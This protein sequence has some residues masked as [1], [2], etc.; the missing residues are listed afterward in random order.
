M[1]ES[2]PTITGYHIEGLDTGVYPEGKVID[3][4][5]AGKGNVMVLEI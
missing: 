4:V 2:L 3:V 1:G 5:R